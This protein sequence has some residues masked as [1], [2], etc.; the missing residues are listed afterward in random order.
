MSEKQD[1]GQPLRTHL[2][3]IE[4]KSGQPHRLLSGRKPL[5]ERAQYLWAWWMEMRL[6]AGPQQPITARTMQDWQWLTGNRLNMRERRAIMALEAHWRNP[7]DGSNPE[8]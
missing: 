7:G 1:D 2:A 6:E 8:D 5:M 3:V 4:R